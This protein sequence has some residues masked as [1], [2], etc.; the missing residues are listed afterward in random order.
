MSQTTT[1]TKAIIARTTNSDESAVAPA[2]KKKKAT[3]TTTTGSSK[4]KEEKRAKLFRKTCP[5]ALQERLERAATQRL[6]LIQQSEI[7]P[8]Y[9]HHHQEEGENHNRVHFTVLGST[10]NVY[11]VVLGLVPSCTCPDYCRRQDMCKHIMFVLLKVIGLEV[12]NPLAYQKAYISSELNEL[13]TIL[14]TRRVGG[15]ILANDQVRAAVAAAVAAAPGS[16]SSTD[17]SSSSS[18]VESSFVQRRSLLEDSDCPICFD[19]LTHEPESK[20]TYCRGTCGANFHEACIRRWLSAMTFSSKPSCPHCRQVWVDENGTTTTT[21]GTTK[22]PAESTYT[23][24]GSLQGLSP[25][26]DS[27][28]YSAYNKKKRRY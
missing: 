15:T 1:T 9:D 8:M 18:L 11:T 19:D 28:T 5:I 20:V 17:L 21:K 23:N 4:E 24:L 2:A 6:Y 22:I 14:R 3:P 16:S 26:R 13:F 12:S 10:G 27:G 25:V 7:P